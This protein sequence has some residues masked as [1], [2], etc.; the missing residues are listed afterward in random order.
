MLKFYPSLHCRSGGA[1][2]NPN[3][4]RTLSPHL[5]LPSPP[6]STPPLLPRDPSGH[7]MGSPLPPRPHTAPVSFQSLQ[8]SASSPYSGVP[9][10]PPLRPY[11]SVPSFQSLHP[12]SPPD[13]YT[14]SLSPPSP[15]TH[16]PPSTHPHPPPP[17]SHHI[18][19]TFTSTPPT[20]PLSPVTLD[21]DSESYI[22]PNPNLKNLE[23]ELLDQRIELA[24]R[25]YVR[26]LLTA[27]MVDLD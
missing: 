15:Y 8:H 17:S 18:T 10:G 21:S 14:P 19:S 22:H 1:G 13:Y 12:T 4:P 2:V 26:E 9:V 20:Q 6:P 11:L 24:A 3:K 16:P 5:H 23:R 25:T 7:P 27:S